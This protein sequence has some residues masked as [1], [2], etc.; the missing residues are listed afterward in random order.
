MSSASSVHPWQRRFCVRLRGSLGP[1]LSRDSRP[2][3]SLAPVAVAQDANTSTSTS[4]SP[5]NRSRAASPPTPSARTRSSSKEL[6][7]PRGTIDVVITDDADFSNG[8]ATPFPTNRIVIYANPPVS[9]SA[10]R[11]T[12]DWGQL[13]ITHELTH[14]FHLDRTRGVWSLA[15]HVFGRAATR[16]SESLRPVVAHRG[17]RR[18]RG[19][20]AR[21]RGTHRRLRTSHDRAR[22]GARATRSRRSARPASAR[23]AI[24]S[25]KRRTRTDR[26]SSTI[27]RARAGEAHV[28]Q[29]VDKSAAN[30]IPY[31]LDIPAKQR[32]RHD[33]HDGVARVQRFRSRA[34]SASRPRRRSSDGASSRTT[35]CSCT[36]R[37]GRPTARS[38]TAARRG[39]RTFAAF[40]VDLNGTP[41][42]HRPAQRPIAQRAARRRLAS[43]RAARLHQSVR[44]AL[45]SLDSARPPPTADHVRRSG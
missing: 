42:A 17:A 35:A 9:E 29:F 5:S 39:A 44:G 32:V 25:A 33:V 4:R 45:R 14:I 19:V 8:S 38:C 31:L 24:R 15:Q 23:D 12:N 41:H 16:L 10:L 43:L 37:A 28:R 20:E 13:V 6:H 7:P 26:C 34:P 18:L 40:R 27:S 11:Y 22:R 30:I 36:R 3:Q 21:R 2:D 1:R